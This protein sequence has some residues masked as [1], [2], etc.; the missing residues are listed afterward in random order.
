M[1]ASTLFHLDPES[2]AF[3]TLGAAR[4]RLKE[5][6]KLTVTVWSGNRDG[7]QFRITV[8]VYYYDKER[9][10]VRR[11]A[12]TAALVEAGLLDRARYTSFH[13]RRAMGLFGGGGTPVAHDTV[14][15]VE[16]F[17]DLTPY[18]I[19]NWSEA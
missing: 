15:L 9:E 7:D 12:L 6:A 14:R 13:G 5:G 11:I 8:D 10:E 1:T 4:A 16:R 18:S 2:Y 17:L 19:S 3:D